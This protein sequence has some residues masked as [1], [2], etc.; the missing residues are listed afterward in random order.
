MTGS[1]PRKPR[2]FTIDDPAL[3]GEDDAWVDEAPPAHRDAA[4]VS[5][6]DA[7][8]PAA[9]RADVAT[10]IRWGSLFV[11]SAMALAGLAFSLWFARFVSEAL[12]SDGVVGWLATSLI[13][14]LS[15][16][17]VGLVVREAVGFVRLQRLER[18]REDGE[19]ALR[20]GSAT[21]EKDVA[22]RVARLYAGRADLSWQLAE[23]REHRRDVNDPGDLLKLADRDVLAAL[24]VQARRII[25]ASAKRVAIVTAISPLA[26]IDVL[27]VFFENVR[28]LRELATLYGGRPG[29]LGG[30]KLGRMV[31]TN[32][33]AAGGI[34][35][36]DDLLGQF[37][38]QDLLRR[39][40]AKL[41]EGAFNGALTARIGVAAIDITR[42]L[43]NIETTPVRVRDIVG[44][45]FKRDAAPEPSEDTPARVRS[46][47]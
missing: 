19:A 18:L 44:E 29:F 42:P 10:G 9:T 24:D 30:L 32:L 26:L 35:L 11:A 37:L 45:L 23:F 21:D 22:A 2:A 43:P 36:T 16:A 14:V 12:A 7:A 27:F 3:G 46:A 5:D 33:I 13:I 6:G 1:K 40:S 28:M 31:L 34:A 4:D 17:A 41:G 15:V 38:G 8:L 20:T 47:V 39:L 25:L